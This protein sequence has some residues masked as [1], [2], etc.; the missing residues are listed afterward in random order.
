MNVRIVYNSL[1][2]YVCVCKFMCV[3]VDYVC[4]L[5]CVVVE[6]IFSVCVCVYEDTWAAQQIWGYLLDIWV[7]MC[8][9]NHDSL[10]E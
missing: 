7:A 8:S 9:Q 4:V 1:C 2:V 3:W 10:T 6:V 5:L